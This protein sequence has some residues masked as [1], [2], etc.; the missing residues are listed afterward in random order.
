MLNASTFLIVSFLF[1]VSD[2]SFQ[3]RYA[4]LFVKLGD[5]I[6][7]LAILCSKFVP[8]IISKRP[9]FSRILFSDIALFLI[10][11]SAENWHNSEG[12]V[13]FPCPAMQDQQ[14]SP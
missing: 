2:R 5:L 4:I 1:V 6:H 12:E 13:R 3:V 11:L 9:C 7:W 10:L 8:K 14:Q